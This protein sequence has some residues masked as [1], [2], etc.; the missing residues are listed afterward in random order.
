MIKGWH[1]VIHDL[2]LMLE[3]ILIA[4]VS[5]LAL[6]LLL[7][8]QYIEISLRIILSVLTWINDIYY[9]LASNQCHSSYN[10]HMNTVA[11][12]C[13]RVTVLVFDF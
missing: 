7:K 2:I 13:S 11:W 3:L 4:E 1:T 5:Q 12:Y 6:V 10:I 9:E 8:I